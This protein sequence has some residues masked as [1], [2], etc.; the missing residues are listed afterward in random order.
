MKRSIIIIP[1][2]LLGLYLSLSSNSAGPASSGSGIRNG[3]PGTNG[4][5][6][7]CHSGGAGTTTMAISLKEKASGT[8]AGGVYKPGTVYTVTLSGNNTNLAFFGFQ[9]TAT[10]PGNAQ[11]GVFSNMG[12]GKHAVPLGGLQVAEHATTLPKTNGSYLAEFDWT[13][14]AAGTGTVTFY[15]IINGVNDDDG[16]GGDRASAPINITLA[17]LAGPTAI[18]DVNP[19]EGWTVYPNPVTDKLHITAATGNYE[20]QVYDLAG[21]QVIK[22]QQKMTTAS[23]GMALNVVSLK[24]GLYFL[25]VSGTGQ[26]IQR[27]FV[28]K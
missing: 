21:H 13:A 19:E 7:S 24:P 3:G 26:R 25:L 22:E 11:A 16:T 6:G 9:L 14:P 27:S 20:F 15:G 12:A 1:V 23:K 17:E 2:V 18:G 28:K 10:G 8:A 5:C 4:N